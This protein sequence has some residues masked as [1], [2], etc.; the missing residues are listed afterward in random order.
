MAKRCCKRGVQ[1]GAQQ[2]GVVHRGS[3]AKPHANRRAKGGGRLLGPQQR[4]GVGTGREAGMG[5]GGGR[6]R[7]AIWPK[8][9]RWDGVFAQ[10]V[11]GWWAVHVC[12]A[13][14]VEPSAVA[15]SSLGNVRCQQ[16][17][18]NLEHCLQ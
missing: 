8:C 14:G 2:W 3:D 15:E 12:V 10:Q 7:K 1:E 11:E 5:T 17:Q 4:S 13:Q 6:R 9:A 18:E 16:Q